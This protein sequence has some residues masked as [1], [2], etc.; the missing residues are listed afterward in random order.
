MDGML[1]DRCGDVAT[2]FHEDFGNV[3]PACAK[4]W[5]RKFAPEPGDR[6]LQGYA[7]R[8]AVTGSDFLDH[9]HSMDY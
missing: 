3:C 9:D 6:E 5:S 1:C 4:H 7:R 2:H 8:A